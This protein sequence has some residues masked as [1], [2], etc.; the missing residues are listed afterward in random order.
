LIITG[1]EI[2][3]EDVLYRVDPDTDEVTIEVVNYHSN[4]SY[5]IDPEGK[6]KIEGFSKMMK[7]S[8]EIDDGIIYVRA[9]DLPQNLRSK[10][11]FANIS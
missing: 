1:S 9:I 7:I 3:P 10:R 2:M 6:S 8:E 11:V 5:F 4:T